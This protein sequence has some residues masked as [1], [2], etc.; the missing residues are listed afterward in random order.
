VT[1]REGKPLHFTE[2]VTHINRYRKSKITN[3]Q[4][5]HNELIK[6]NRLVLVG[7]GTYGLK[8]FGI[9]PGTAREVIQHFIQKHGPLPAK[10][11][12]KLVL[13][14]RMFKE[15]TLLINLQNKDFFKRLGDGRY[16]L[17]EA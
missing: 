3:V 12:V 11:V 6:D 5:V 4:T 2:L 14:E 13:A 15:G 10:E 9:L 7:R 16:G 1:K 8:E 17:R